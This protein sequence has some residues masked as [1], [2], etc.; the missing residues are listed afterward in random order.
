M[1]R[2]SLRGTASAFAITLA[3]AGMVQAQESAETVTVT[4]VRASVN[5]A[6]EAKQNAGQII[7]SIVA[8]DIGKLPDSTLVESLQHVSGVSILRNNV[9][10][11]IVLIRGLPDVQTL[12][13]GRAIFSSAPTNGTTGRNVV[14]ADFPSEL[15]AQV[16]VHK[17][18]SATDIEGGI[19]G[20]IDIRLHRPF[21]FDGF[22]FAFSGQGVNGSLSDH[23]DPQASF[24]ISDRW[25]T[26]IGEIGVLVDVSYKNIHVR[27]DQVLGGVRS[28]IIGPVPG[29]GSFGG[30]VCTM[31]PITSCPIRNVTLPAG[32]LGS[33]GLNV[34]F[35]QGVRPGYAAESSNI[36]LFQRNGSV[37]RA[38]L[39]LSAQWKPTERVEVFAE[40]FYSRLRQKAPSFVDVKLRSNCP[41]AAASTVFPGSNIVATGKSGCYS[42]TSEQDRRNKEDTL[43]MAAGADWLVTDNFTLTAEVDATTSKAMTINI[44][45]D[46]AYNYPLDGL[47]FDNNYQ[48]SGGAFV[49]TVGDPQLDPSK[50]ILDQLFDQRN[51]A[52]GADYV[53]RLDGK[54]EF[55]PSSY[56]KSIE[57]G[58]RGGARSS[59]NTAAANAA[60]N[61]TQPSNPTL[62]YNTDIVSVLNSPV[63]KAF[64]AQGSGGNSPANFTTLGGVTVASLGAGAS[65]RTWGSFFDGRFGETGWTT[66]EPDWLWN[67]VEKIRNLYGLTGERPD[68]P[69]ATFIVNEVTQSTY[70]KANYGFD[71]W[72]IPIDGNVGVR[73]VDTQL[74]EQAYKTD[75]ST[76]VITFTP[77]TARK[78]T[79]DLLP[80]FNLRATLDDGLFLR[81]SASKT[82]TRPSFS[83]LN[84]AQ[85]FSGAGQTLLGTSASGNPNLNAVKSVNL[86]VSG[87][88]Y[89]GHGNHVSAAVFHRDVKGYIQTA[90]C[91][92][93]QA[94]CVNG[95][96]QSNGFF[97]N[98]S[99]PQNL[100][101]AT[102][103]GAEVGYSQFLD[104]LPG[105][106]SGFGWDSNATY[107][108]GPFNN[109]SKWSYNAA[110]I[111]EQGPYSLR[112]SYTWR[113]TSLFNPAFTPG[114][115]PQR[116]YA[117][118]RENL[119]F[120]F[121]Y[122]WDDNLILTFDATNIINS[123]FKTFAGKQSAQDFLL[124]NVE[125][126]QFDKTYSIGLRYRL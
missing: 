55:S 47:S 20:L 22:K 1:H 99:L 10:P 113:S 13:N 5:S 35:A 115:Q 104:F 25:N 36:S 79:T 12:L 59:H 94:G 4:G 91:T 23:I 52:V 123:Q 95:Q 85:S 18:S 6:L 33:G 119:D 48:G 93:A 116:L 84:P 42:L 90:A 27:Q 11:T 68:V 75:T 41:D 15:L 54:Y 16:D 34:P 50:L 64:L 78:G 97:Y 107:V 126:S 60:L 80:S 49:S 112:L 76:G 51:K 29:A 3:T 30:S 103:E 124:Y 111:Y 114:V 32:P 67:N 63:C 96:V 24:L 71:I 83:Q 57:L 108:S 92:S 39:N 61:C 72:N 9:E 58:W 46:T 110:G 81:F 40:A 106:L 122:T 17:A 74:T 53:F 77:T 56:I 62:A 101:D 102:L 28:T 26:E 109:I 37:E 7:D 44:I 66:F 21:D 89:W 88:Y 2:K 70:I 65:R 19:A 121:N 125:I 14:L 118:P 120:S 82:V 105:F 98:Y 86:D 38:S 73:Y 31:S 43:Q 100:Q 87:E 8:E 69:S 117:R 45:P